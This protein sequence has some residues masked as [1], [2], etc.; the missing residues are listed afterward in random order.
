MAGMAAEVV[1]IDDAARALVLAA[2]RGRVGERYIVSERY[3]PYR[4]LYETAAR[5]AGGP[6]PRWGIPQTGDEVRRRVGSIAA[7][8]ARRDLQ[9][10]RTSVRLMEIMAPMDHSKAVRELG[11]QPR[12]ATIRSGKPSSSSDGGTAASRGAEPPIRRLASGHV[13]IVSGMIRRNQCTRL[14]QRHVGARTRHRPR[15]TDDGGPCARAGVR[16]GHSQPRRSRGSIKA[17]HHPKRGPVTWYA[18]DQV[19]MGSHRPWDSDGEQL[20]LVHSAAVSMAVKFRDFDE[21]ARWVVLELPASR[22]S[23]LLTSS[24][25]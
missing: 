6:A 8:V 1:G 25:R 3:L 20:P 19:R 24:G 18:L 13:P 4:E 14:T 9:L 22:A 5:A 11:W 12:P 23:G 16:G 10:S 15:R 21:L 17:L 2:D 7:A